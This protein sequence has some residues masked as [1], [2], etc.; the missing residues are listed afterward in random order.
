[1]T[2][3]TDVM[4]VPRIGATRTIDL[5]VQRPEYVAAWR[6]AQVAF[7]VAMGSGPDATPDARRIRRSGTEWVNRR[8]P[9]ATK[10]TFGRVVQCLRLHPTGM[11]ARQMSDVL[12]VPAST[13]R[14]WLGVAVG[15]GIA[16]GT[17][18]RDPEHRGRV[19]TYTLETTT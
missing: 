14:H 3:P 12:N 2:P 10:G 9:D 8:P 16:T 13:C 6:A 11:T 7:A 1:M 5:S 4:P 17:M 15:S 18:S 19:T